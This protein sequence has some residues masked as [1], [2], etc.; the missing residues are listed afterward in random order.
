MNFC[1]EVCSSSSISA[2]EPTPEP[3]FILPSLTS[4]RVRSTLALP[5]DFCNAAIEVL[6]GNSAVSNLIREGKTF[7]I[8]GIMQTGKKEG[9]QT[10]EA[11]VRALVDTG[12]VSLAEARAYL[13]RTDTNGTSGA[14]ELAGVH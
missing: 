4:T 12:R 11:A 2:L 7:Q 1:R 9:M 8:P 6:I 13:P 5:P 10:M 3:F 14:R